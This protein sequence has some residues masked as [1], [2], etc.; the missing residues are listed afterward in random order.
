M[1]ISLFIN[2]DIS[3]FQWLINNPE[4]LFINTYKR[5]SINYMVLHKSGCR[6]FKEPEQ[7]TENKFTGN[8]YI[9]I[10]SND[11]NDLMK[12][13]NSYDGKDFSKTCKH[14]DPALTHS[15]NGKFRTQQEYEEIFQLQVKIEQSNP[16]K[17]VALL[18]EQKPEKIEVTTYIFKRDPA[19]VITALRRASGICEHCLNAAPFI[20]DSDGTPYL[21]VHHVKSLSEGGADSINNVK[22]LCPNCHR[23]LHYG[24]NSQRRSQ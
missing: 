3:F 13:I 1:N 15:R 2:D 7:Y 12:F 10:C 16:S 6:N 20:R 18:Q 5:P 11:A 17:Q 21:E 19:V 23:Y 14:C 24:K 8:A 9:K 22:A 4:G